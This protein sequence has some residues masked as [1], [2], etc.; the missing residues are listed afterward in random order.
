[1]LALFFALSLWLA[2]C[3]T[4]VEPI[5]LNGQTMGTTWSAVISKPVGASKEELARR[6]QQEL[7]RVNK[8][9]STYDPSSELSLFNSSVSEDWQP[10]SAELVDLIATAKK[11]TEASNGGF[12]VTV[13]PLV[14]LWGFG[15][16]A[17]PETVP[18]E[19]QI[20]AAKALVGSDQVLIGENPS[21]LKKQA[22]AVYVDLSAIAKGYGVDQMALLLE[23]QGIGDYLVEIG[24]ELRANGLSPRGDSWR[25]GIERPSEAERSIQQAVKLGDGALATS[26]DYRNY[27][28]R[29]GV[30]Y[31]HTIDARTGKP[32]E[33]KLAS[34][35]VYHESTALAD[36]WATALMV[37]GEVEGPKVADALGLAAYFLYREG[38]SFAHYQTQSF[39]PLIEE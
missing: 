12:D 24:G 32:V 4:K 13:G 7:D 25:I 11:I 2:G 31:A 23:K 37:L 6:I 38:D 33:H 17:E 30:R 20:S 36:G 3:S 26:G 39:A 10:Q 34:V 28:E 22:A 18:S 27:Y 35:S 9:M 8:L 15:P 14:N 19:E 16:E 21:S 1:M 29:D 5:T